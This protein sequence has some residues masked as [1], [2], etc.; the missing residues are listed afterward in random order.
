MSTFETVADLAGE[1][2]FALEDSMRNRNMQMRSSM[3]DN[4]LFG[5]HS[6]PKQ[7]SRPW[8]P[9]SS[10]EERL[11]VRIGSERCSGGLSYILKKLYLI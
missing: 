10:V 8:M 1:L 5:G 2:M 6:N 3:E 11:P 4:R 7:R 9:L